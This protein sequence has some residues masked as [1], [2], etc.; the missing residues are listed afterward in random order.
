LAALAACVAWLSGL[1]LSGVSRLLRRLK[2]RYR[3]GQEH[4]H[5]PDPDYDKKMQAVK[6]AR[7]KACKRPGKVVFVYQD[8]FSYYRRASVA[9]A[10]HCQGGPGRYAQQGHSR[11]KKRRVIGA[12]NAIDGRL[13]CWQRSKAGVRTLVRFYE[14]LQAAYPDAE[15]IYVAQDNWPVHFHDEVVKSLKGSKIKLLPLPTYAPWT[16]PIEKVWRWLKQDVL[17]QH[18]FGDDWQGL[19]DAVTEWLAKWAGPSPALLRYVGLAQK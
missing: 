2:V 12:L 18:D 7:L 10:W 5:S 13:F 15:V 11:N 8:E 16:N 14:A 4:L 3:R 9:Q 6:R 19:Q 1:S 17:H